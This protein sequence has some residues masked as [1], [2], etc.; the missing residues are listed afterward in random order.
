M[1]VIVTDAKYRSSLSVIRALAD[2][3]HEIVLTQTMSDSHPNVPSF[4]SRYVSRTVGF[5]CSADDSVSYLLALTSL[6]KEYDNPVVFPIGVKTLALISSHRDEFEKICRYQVPD[7]TALD[8]A[9]DK[10]RVARAAQDLG[11]KTPPTYT[12][13]DDIDFPVVVKPVC[14]ES[15]GL[16]AADRYAVANNPAEFDS[17]Y[18]KMSQYGGAPIIQ[19]KITGTGI[20]ISLLMDN[21]G[22]A[23][24]AICHKRVR[25]YPISGGPSACCESFYNEELVKMS[26]LLLSKIGFVGMAMVEYKLDGDE[27]SPN[28][29]YLLEINPR[30]WG[31]FP[32][33]FV[34]KTGFVSDY[35]EASAGNTVSHPLDNYESGARM[36]FILSDLAAIFSLIKH[37]RIKK[38]VE[39][40][41]DIIFHRAVDGMTDKNDKTP[42]K[43]YLKL[44]LFKK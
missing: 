2:C 26:E 6:I 13:G 25:E 27:I 3:G 31:S 38:G 41:N 29:A 21:N 35:V 15:F 10:S 5:L 37:G 40:L 43:N 8:F 22:K 36:N 44:K 32:L 34:A 23:I 11:I 33:T 18:K 30:V 12:A 4:T 19:K 42:F 28:N 20:G 17:V 9:N 14:G 1:T 24:S 39:G 16:P 7:K